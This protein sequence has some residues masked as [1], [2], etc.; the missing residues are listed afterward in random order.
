MTVYV[1][2][3]G[4]KATVGRHTSSWSHLTVGPD[5]DIEELHRFAVGKLRLARA[6]FQ[7]PPKHPWPRSHY[8]VTAGKRLRA[9]QLGAVACSWRDTG[10]RMIDAVEARY[11]AAAAQATALGHDVER[12]PGA[13]TCR[14]CGLS[15][16][17][18]GFTDGP[19]AKN[20]CTTTA[21][22]T[23]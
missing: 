14:A 15:A 21:A 11:A 18:R 7:G 19:A 16:L 8:D 12:R 13:V 4:E 23:A 22:V 10:R 2:D 17:E 1:D 20:G 5:D 6:W 9:I 3:W